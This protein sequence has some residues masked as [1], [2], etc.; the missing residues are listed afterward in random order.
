MWRRW[1]QLVR[2]SLK[3]KCPICEEE[4]TFSFTSPHI[5]PVEDM[6]VRVKRRPISAELVYYI[7]SRRCEAQL[8]G[9]KR[10]RVLGKEE[11]DRK[12]ES[13]RNRHST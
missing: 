5:V 8:K 10:K 3:V 4:L 6:H 13:M 11:A 9:F 12:L 1:S 2:Y 7:G